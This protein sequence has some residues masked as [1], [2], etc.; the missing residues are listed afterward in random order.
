MNSEPL[1]ARETLP[2]RRDRLGRA[3]ARSRRI[4]I[5]IR[6]AAGRLTSATAVLKHGRLEKAPAHA[7]EQAVSQYEDVQNEVVK[8]ADDLSQVNTDLSIEVAERESIETELAETKLDLAVARDDLVES[9]ASEEEALHQALHDTL[10]G[11]PNRALFD[12]GL[13]HG[14]IQAHR[15]GWGLAVLFVDIDDFKVINDTHGHQVGDDVLLMVAERL[16][17]FLRA[18]DMV[19][20]W[21]GDEYACSLLEVESE[22]EVTRLAK[23]MC[24]SIAE[25]FESGGVTLSIRCSIGIALYPDHGD[26]ADVLLKNADRAM[27]DAKGT[28]DEVVVY[29]PDLES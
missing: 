1:E 10:T 28:E 29:A 21:G 8:A 2:T 25:E 24:R 15:H 22:A 16:R 27:Y 6:R 14:L 13:E 11:L 12:Q 3:L 26:S 17:S 7:V 19:S 4:R 18:E 5:A 9:R 20:R 23:R